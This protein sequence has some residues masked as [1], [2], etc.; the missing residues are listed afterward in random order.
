MA[1]IQFECYI[2]K[3][4]F[5]G[6]QSR[7]ITEIEIT[8]NI[9]WHINISTVVLKT[10]LSLKK[11]SSISELKTTHTAKKNQVSR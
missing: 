9:L 2:T 5:L 11:N 1:A 10:Y 8:R 7:Y 6:G 3:K 4:Y